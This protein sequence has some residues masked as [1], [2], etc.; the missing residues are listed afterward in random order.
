M[1]DLPPRGAEWKQAIFMGRCSQPELL[2]P[3][4]CCLLWLRG[5][6]FCWTRLS[7]KSSLQ[8]FWLSADVRGLSKRK[9][10]ERK[11]MGVK[12]NWRKPSVMHGK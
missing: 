7:R 2:V 1:Q 8:Y 6:G 11:G 3:A 12:G 10:R 4:L 5:K 9:K